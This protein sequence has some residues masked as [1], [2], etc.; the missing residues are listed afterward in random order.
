MPELHALLL[1]SREVSTQFIDED[2]S[3]L[4]EGLETETSVESGL[5]SINGVKEKLVKIQSQTDAFNKNLIIYKS[6]V[7]W[8]RVLLQ[9]N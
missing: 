3:A 2:Y 9:E 7:V 5:E 6:N 1:A 4:K 8:I